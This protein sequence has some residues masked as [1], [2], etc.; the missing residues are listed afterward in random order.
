MTISMWQIDILTNYHFQME[1]DKICDVS[2]FNFFYKSNIFWLTNSNPNLVKS[3][4]KNMFY[5]ITYTINIPI[6]FKI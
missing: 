3:K 1:N 5:Y 6:I 2:H 4:N